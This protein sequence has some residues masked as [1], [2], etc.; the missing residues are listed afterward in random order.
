VVFKLFFQVLLSFSMSVSEKDTTPS[1]GMFTWLSSKLL[2]QFGSVGETPV[3]LT[4]DSQEVKG[5]RS[6]GVD[7]DKGYLLREPVM[8]DSHISLLSPT[9]L[10]RGTPKGEIV[11]E[12]AVA[13]VYSVT[14][15]SAAGDT[16]TVVPIEASIK[17]ALEQDNLEPGQ[18]SGM[19]E[20]ISDDVDVVDVDL[21]HANA[22]M[23]RGNHNT[24]R[25]VAERDELLLSDSLVAQHGL[26]GEAISDIEDHLQIVIANARYDAAQER[27]TAMRAE[28][29]A[30]SNRM[31]EAMVAMND[32]LEGRAKR[33]EE[34]WAEKV[35]KMH[36]DNDRMQALYQQS[37]TAHR[38][39]V[40]TSAKKVLSVSA[41]QSEVIQLRGDKETW[42]TQ[43]EVLKYLD[44]EHPQ[45]YVDSDIPSMPEGVRGLATHLLRHRQKGTLPVPTQPTGGGNSPVSHLGYQPPR[46]TDAVRQEVRF[47]GPNE[48]AVDTA[49]LRGLARGGDKGGDLLVSPITSK[50]TNPEEVHTQTSSTPRP[51]D[52]TYE[53]LQQLTTA[54][55]NIQRQQEQGLKQI[56]S[57]LSLELKENL[58]GMIKYKGSETEHTRRVAQVD[59]CMKN[60]QNHYNQDTIPASRFPSAKQRAAEDIML[61]DVVKQASKGDKGAHYDLFD[62]DQG[63]AGEP[64]VTEI[65][66]N[67]TAKEISMGY[68]PS[69]FNVPKHEEQAIGLFYGGEEARTKW[70]DYHAN[71]EHVA[72][73]YGWGYEMKG[74][75][76]FRKCRS[77]AIHVINAQPEAKRQD[78]KTLVGAFHKAYIPSQWARA[79]RGAMAQR[80]QKEQESFLAYSADL[81]KMAY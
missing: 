59:G 60:L 51:L 16:S 80:K 81:R 35:Q 67:A 8:P 77:F 65:L 24:E 50:H 14:V 66:G 21:L 48:M 63:V 44:K 30:L 58:E 37:L 13:N 7:E 6:A 42:L 53:C 61:M 29:Q 38:E 71:F 56:K 46:Y 25:V 68:L 79:Y 9:E 40:S 2:S 5:R 20:G 17:Y 33:R 43:R 39:L 1:R 3:T 28:F 15:H 27:E 57:D 41:L 74:A 22:S 64:E 49:Q 31:D 34:F 75:L 4:P 55:M 52:P 73:S 11:G 78:Y 18:R 45:G 26:N 12:G 54:V 76:L 62:F 32:G 23:S 10:H 72:S 36:G 70:P 47:Q 69:R 19:E